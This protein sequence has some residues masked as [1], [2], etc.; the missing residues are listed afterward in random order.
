MS[1]GRSR[2]HGHRSAQQNLRLLIVFGFSLQSAQQMKRDE[3]VGCELQE[4][5]IGRLCLAQKSR[6]VQLEGAR[7]QRPYVGFLPFLQPGILKCTL[8]DAVAHESIPAESP[9]EINMEGLSRLRCAPSELR[10]RQPHTSFTSTPP[11][12][13]PSG[14]SSAFPTR[15]TSARAH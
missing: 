4:F 1:F 2:I 6:F 3:L 11:P 8:A 10:G 5:A 14:T 13:L 15:S 12:L 9:E 7:E